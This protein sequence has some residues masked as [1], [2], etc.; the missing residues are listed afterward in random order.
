MF[1]DKHQNSFHQTAAVEVDRLTTGQTCRSKQT[2]TFVFIVSFMS[3]VKNNNDTLI[4][5]RV[6][7]FITVPMWNIHIH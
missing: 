2:N 4:R 5:R 6:Y 7:V 3:T 1:T